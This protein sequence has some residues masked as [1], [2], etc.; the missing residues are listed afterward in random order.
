MQENKQQTTRQTNGRNIN[1]NNGSNVKK[2]FSVKTNK[3]LVTKK[4]ASK[5]RATR[6]VEVVDVHNNEKS[7]FPWSIVLSVVLFTCLMLFMMMNYAEVN[8]YK[9]EIASL[10]S[11][12]A[13]LEKQYDDLHVTYSNKYDFKEIIEYA[14]EELDMVHSNQISE[15]H[16]ITVEQKDKTEMYNYEDEKDGGIGFLLTGFGEIFKDYFGE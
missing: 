15:R 11:K 6:S 2:T 13:S 16:V 5:L 9:N 1:N 12:I 4:R 7:P 3:N 10:D 14:T 8:K